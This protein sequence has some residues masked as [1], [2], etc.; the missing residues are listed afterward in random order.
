VKASRCRVYTRRGA[1]YPERCQPVPV[2]DQE[3]DR[4]EARLY[5]KNPGGRSREAVCGPPLDLE[6]ESVEAGCYAHAG[7]EQVRA[8]QEDGGNQ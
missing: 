4:W 8:I 7:C 1:D 2:G 6:P 5:R 3:R